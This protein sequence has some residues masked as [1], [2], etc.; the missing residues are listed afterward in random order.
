MFSRIS[1]LYQPDVTMH[2]PPPPGRDKQMS[3]KI[4]KKPWSV[5][6]SQKSTGLSSQYP[7]MD[8]K[9][10]PLITVNYSRATLGCVSSSYF[11]PQ[12]LYMLI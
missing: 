6:G 5:V 9:Q 8:G 2:S 11:F 4:A 10:C 12:A 7:G 1:S 3:L